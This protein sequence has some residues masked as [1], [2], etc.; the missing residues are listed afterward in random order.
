MQNV[1][2]IPKNRSEAMF[3]D[4]IIQGH[5][6]VTIE[7]INDSCKLE[8]IWDIKLSGMMGMFTGMIKKHIQSGTEQAL[9]SIKKEVEN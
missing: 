5:K 9:E 3:T 8:A 2:L 4:G 7:Q 1:T 6:I